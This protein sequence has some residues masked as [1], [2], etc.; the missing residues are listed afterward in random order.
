MPIRQTRRF[1]EILRNDGLGAAL[2]TTNRFVLEK[3]PLGSKHPTLVK[4]NSRTAYWR[5]RLSYS[6]P[7]RPFETIRIEAADVEYNARISYSRGLG[8]VEG[9]DW[10]ERGNLTP[11]DDYP[12]FEG[13]KQR[14][15]RGEDWEDTAYVKDATERIR[16]GKRRTA[17]TPSESSSTSGVPTSK[18]SLR[19]SE[20]TV[21][22]RRANTSIRTGRA[23]A[24][25]DSNP[26]LRSRETVRYTSRT[27]ANID[28]LSHRYSTYGFPVTSPSGTNAGSRFGTRCTNRN[29]PT[30]TENRTRIPTWRTS[31]DLA[32]DFVG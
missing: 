8:R 18:T 28:S 31:S 13:L 3:T 9:G 14:F 25:T 32:V 27:A 21:I 22:V 19:R 15:E 26:S 23:R 6:A 12:T 16:A 29:E 1:F 20:R 4:L 7:A 11:V 24:R 17:V 30:G 5:N 2:E 10:D